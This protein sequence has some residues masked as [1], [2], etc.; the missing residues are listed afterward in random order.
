MQGGE[1]AMVVTAA[2]ATDAKNSSVITTGT[3]TRTLPSAPADGVIEEYMNTSGTLTIARGGTDT[4]NHYA[5]SAMTSLVIPAG[6]SVKLRYKASSGI[7]YVVA[8][9]FT[10]DTILAEV[11]YQVNT[12]YT[13]NGG[14]LAAVDR[15]NLPIT[16]IGPPCGHVWF[17]WDA[18]YQCNTG[19]APGQ[20][21]ACI[22]DENANTLLAGV[23]QALFAY[24]GRQTDGNL[25][26]GLFR[27][28][29]AVTAGTSYKWSPAAAYITN[30]CT[31]SAGGSNGWGAFN[32]RAYVPVS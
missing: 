21:N 14:A 11:S 24:T 9:G 19:G 16:F 22:W 26:H 13:L 18:G 20:I 15:T 10:V 31:L 3:C 4:I 1:L 7:W 29:V 25:G 28:K 30:T 6:M 12:T 2:S 5:T 17:E 32:V 27:L 23:N 8:G